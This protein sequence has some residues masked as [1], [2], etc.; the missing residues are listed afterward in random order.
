MSRKVSAV[1]LPAIEQAVS[2]LLK[3]H[4]QPLSIGP[5]F[6]IEPG[7]VWETDSILLAV[8]Q[9]SVLY[10]RGDILFEE[11]TLDFL[12]HSSVMNH[13][14]ALWL[15]SLAPGQ[16]EFALKMATNLVPWWG[17]RGSVSAW[18]NRFGVFHSGQR[19]E[20]EVAARYTT[21]FLQGLFGMRSTGTG[22]H[23][24]VGAMG[25]CAPE[26]FSRWVGPSDVPQ[27]LGILLG[28]RGEKEIK[29]DNVGPEFAKIRELPALEFRSDVAG[30]MFFRMLDR[31]EEGAQRLAPLI[32]RLRTRL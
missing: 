2:V 19:N 32:A 16:S 23:Q 29:L 5:D 10:A 7:V 15:S 9:R 30:S 24:I 14:R 21:D 20:I 13:R 26:V 12:S 3:T 25:P 31:A 27:F 8:S 1:G 4:R 18:L 6:I 22:F 17:P 11:D 28:S